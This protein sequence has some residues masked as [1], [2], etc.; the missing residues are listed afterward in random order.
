M[1]AMIALVGEQP[2]PNFLPVRHDHPSDVVLVYTA[3]T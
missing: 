3:K 1:T 2:L